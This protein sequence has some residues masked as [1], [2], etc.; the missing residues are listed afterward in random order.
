MTTKTKSIAE[1]T[2]KK[3]CLLVDSGKLASALGRIA[4]VVTSNPI[5]PI[6]DNVLMTAEEGRLTCRVSDLQVDAQVGLEVSCNTPFQCAVPVKLLLELLKSLPAQEVWFRYEPNTF[7]LTLEV[8]AGSYQLPGENPV[9]FPK[10]QVIDSPAQQMDAKVLSLALHQVAF[11]VSNDELRPSMT[12]V[13]I[14]ANEAGTQFCATDGHRLATF[15]T[16]A[17]SGFAMIIPA[18]LIRLLL[19]T[20]P[21]E[22]AVSFFTNNSQVR[23][24]WSNLKLQ[25]RLIDERYPDYKNAIPVNQPNKAVL[26]KKA[27]IDVIRRAA[28]FSELKYIVALAFAEDGEVTISAADGMSNRSSKERIHCDTYE[29]ENLKIGFNGKMLVEGLSVLQS[30]TVTLLLA[31]ANR[32]VVIE[33]E[34]QPEGGKVLQILMPHM[35]TDYA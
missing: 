4:S 17:T 32:A 2:I 19:K 3:P 9:D 6:L 8:L 5:V 34:E 10:L 12:G 18:K 14:E 29:G 11:A 25:S 27:L 15:S 24:E 26:S 16:E 23:F 7:T 30:E 33:P 22:G 1:P 20:M 13:Y 28:L 35:L 21:Q 31:A